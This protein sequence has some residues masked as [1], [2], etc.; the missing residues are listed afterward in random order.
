[1]GKKGKTNKVKYPLQSGN[2]SF[3]IKYTSKSTKKYP[4]GLFGKYDTAVKQFKK[5][6]SFHKD[7]KALNNHNDELFS[8]FNITITHNDLCNII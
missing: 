2:N 8:M 3:G 7:L 1:M 6:D 5:S 4:C